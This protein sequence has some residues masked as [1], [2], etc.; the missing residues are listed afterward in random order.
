[1]QRNTGYFPTE[2]LEP[3]SNRLFSRSALNEGYL[4]RGSLGLSQEMLAE[5]ASLTKAH[6]SHI[7]NSYSKP[8]VQTLFQIAHALDITA[9]ELL[10]DYADVSMDEFCAVI[11]ELCA[12]CSPRE[13]DMILSVVKTMTASFPLLDHE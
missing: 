13:R 7:E 9:N 5:K 3:S 1:M 11:S 12:D 2:S 4:F 8:S 10:Y 6:I